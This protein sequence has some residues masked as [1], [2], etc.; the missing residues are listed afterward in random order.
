MLRRDRNP[1]PFVVSRGAILAVPAFALTIVACAIVTSLG[2]WMM[3]I[4]LGVLAGL[5]FV[6]FIGESVVLTFGGMLLCATAGIMGASIE[7]PLFGTTVRDIGVDQAALYPHASIFHFTDGRV[8]TQADGYVPVYGGSKGQHHELYKLHIAP[9][10]GTGWTPDRPIA[11]WAVT[12]SPNSDM[13]RSDWTGPAHAGVRVISSSG[14]DIRDAIVRAA[15]TYNL[16][17]AKDVVLLHWLPDP[18]A[19]VSGQYWRL[20]TIFCV[21][22][23]IW[24]V[25]VASTWIFA[26]HRAGPAA[27]SPR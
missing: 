3:A 22:A 4:V 12:S 11:A 10:V 2:G 24:G 6:I 26:R 14:D 17:P 5:G 15:R 8:L 25:L 9:I 27:R 7:T 16:T 18:E 23:V 19:A 20:F 1:K 13:P 21:C